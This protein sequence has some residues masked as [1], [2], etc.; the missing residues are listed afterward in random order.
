MILMN[1]RSGVPMGHVLCVLVLVGIALSLRLYQLGRASFWIDEVISLDVAMQEL[2]EIVR[3]YRPGRYPWGGAD[4]A[5]LSP[6][7]LNLF[8]GP[9]VSETAAR[10]PSALFGVA[11]VI[12]LYLTV[13]RWFAQPVPFLA[14]AAL[15]L[16][17]LHVW[18][19]QETRWYAHWML[20]IL[21]S[22]AALVWAWRSGAKRAWLAYAGLSVLAVYTFAM[23]FLFLACQAV[24]V[25]LL[26]SVRPRRTG[27][28]AAFVL[29]QLVVLL[30]SIPVLRVILG[31]PDMASGTPRPTSWAEIPYTFF[32]YSVGYS[33]GPPLRELHSLPSL[34]SIVRS[35]PSVVVI[36]AV[37]APLVLLG[38][39]RL[40]KDAGAAAVLL[41]WVFGPALLVLALSI[42]SANL[43]Y[44]ARYSSASLPAF[45]LL[46]SLG[47]ASLRLPL[48]RGAAAAA[49]CGC[50]ALSLTNYYTDPR[51]WKEDV[52]TAVGHVRVSSL[53]DAPV[54]VVG[55]IE[56]VARYYAPDLELVVLESCQVADADRVADA[57]VLWLMIGR[58]WEREAPACIER[59]LRSH[60]LAA[61]REF[62]GVHLQLFAQR[63]GRGV[64]SV[65][66]VGDGVED[67]HPR[68]E[69][70][71]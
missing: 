1:K 8:V 14:A 39:R 55:Q 57:P 10:L 56:Q 6:L 59:L 66:D 36:G 29:V 31:A 47:I 53:N 37:F 44:Q 62:P 42:A 60:T 67:R 19:S 17:P 35:Y 49:A 45:L 11:T 28:M 38:I 3:N 21:L 16:S 69:L 15:A 22:Y 64:M 70:R 26:G 25:L 43:T 34:I 23:S 5:P 33:A 12:A 24:S 61:K 46:V 13:R 20:F 48:A 63:T 32:A 40:W 7:M 9:Q 4:Q 50:F 30:L 52:K 41:P 51:Y 54:A 18:Y 27:P 58:D 2:G 68:R 71:G 65:R